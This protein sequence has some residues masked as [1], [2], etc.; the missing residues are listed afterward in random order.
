MLLFQ[1]AHVESDMLPTMLRT[2]E[3][4]DSGGSN[5]GQLWMRPKAYKL[6]SEG[7]V[8]SE[9]SLSR[10]EPGGGYHTLARCGIIATRVGL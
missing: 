2:L 6:G 7:P 10:M 3:K 4:N 5:I 8:A 9:A 1:G